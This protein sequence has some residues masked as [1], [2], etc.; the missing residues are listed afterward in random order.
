MHLRRV[1]V[2][3]VGIAS[4]CAACTDG[5]WVANGDARVRQVHT[6]TRGQ[7]VNA[8]IVLVADG[9]DLRQAAL[10]RISDELAAH[11][12]DAPRVAWKS[13]DVHV[14]IV[15][16]SE[17]HRVITGASDARLTWTQDDADPR[18]LRQLVDALR[19][20]TGSEAGSNDHPLEA[21]ADLGDL[22]LERRR[23]RNAD[24]EDLLRVGRA[25]G[26]ALFVV[27]TSKDDASSGDP[28]A[29]ASR[30]AGMAVS[31]LVPS[32]VG[33]SCEEA[34][35]MP[36]I[37]SF[38]SHARAQ[39]RGAACAETGTFVDISWSDPPPGSLPL[40]VAPLRD[41]QT[42]APDCRV[43]VSARSCDRSRGWRG[44]DEPGTCEVA[45]LLGDDLEACRRG[46]LP[47][48]SGWMIDDSAYLGLRLRFTGGGLSSEA[49]TAVTCNLE[50]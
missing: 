40:P 6:M 31:I 36:R 20:R 39:V 11:V 30:T 9:S 49:T 19:E 27:V 7:T 28:V 10:Q 37:A 44:G 50:P 14:A 29:Y 34:A 15:S 3:L 16:P 24:E 38:A 23:A 42:G 5:A 18:R 45:P 17:G 1:V 41:L 2:C 22:L 35:G 32:A 46:S 47:C 13:V 12:G 43:T 25:L 8:L 33:V 4:T 48:A 26:R 21:V